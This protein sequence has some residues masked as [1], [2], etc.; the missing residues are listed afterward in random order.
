MTV[1]ASDTDKD[2]STTIMGS[3]FGTMQIYI[4]YTEMN[5]FIQI[6]CAFNFDLICENNYVRYNVYNTI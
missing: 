5:G 3:D 1:G 4:C 2:G 6:S